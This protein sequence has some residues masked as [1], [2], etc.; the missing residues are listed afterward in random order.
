MKT[1][2][3][4]INKGGLGDHL[5]F[6]HLPK[7]AKETGSF[8]QVL[9]SEQSIFRSP[10]TRE[11][12]W[13]ANPYLDGFTPAKGIVYFPKQLNAGENLLDNILL[14]YGIDDG[15]RMHEPM[16]FYQPKLK[17]ELVGK[18]LYD[19]NFISYTGNLASGKRI[20]EWFEKENRLPNYVMS[21]LGNR[22]LA[23]SSGLPLSAK[24]LPDFCDILYSVKDIYCLTT[25]TATLAAAFNKPA[26]VFYGNGHDPLYRHAPMH[27]YL[28]LGTDF[29]FMNYAKSWAAK[30]IQ[31]FIP[32][33]TP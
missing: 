30:L 22:Y 12:V 1:L 9:L 27:Q 16:L 25:G 11:M 21:P 8:D 31:Q 2:V 29:G 20:E 4:Q 24:S 6:S 32:L 33:G 15:Q 23:I 10:A 7:I 13:E 19:P 18:S 26:T 28:C 5:F 17:E 14:H 3:I